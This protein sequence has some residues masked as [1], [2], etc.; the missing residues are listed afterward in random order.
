MIIRLKTCMMLAFSIGVSAAELP[1]RHPYLADSVNPLGHGDAAQQDSVSVSGPVNPGAMVARELIQY[2]PSGPAQFGA[3]TSGPYPN[4]SRVFWANGLDRIVKI[5][6]DTFEILSTYWFD[7][8]KRWTEDEADSAI[9]YFNK[10]KQGIGSVWRAFQEASKLKEL[11]GVYTV[12]D[13]DNTYFIADKYGTVTAYGD[14]NPMDPASSI[15]AKRSFSLPA[16]VT[17]YTVGMNM[18]YDGWLVV[19]TEHGY[20]VAISRD[21][22]SSYVVKLHNSDN[23]EIKATRPTGYGWVRNSIAIDAYGGIYVASQDHMHKIIWTGSGFSK[24]RDNGAWTVP[25][26]NSW[27]H[28]TGATPSLMGFGNEDQFVVITDGEHLMNVVLFWRNEI[29]EDWEGLSGFSRRIAGLQPANMGNPELTNI[30]SEQAV[31]IAGYG[32]LVVNNEP[33]NAPWWVPDQAKKLL[34]SYLGSSPT[35]QPYGVQKFTWNPKSRRFRQAWVNRTVSSP[36]CVPIVSRTSDLAFLIGARNSKWTLEAVEWQTG[37]SAYHSIIGDERYN[38]F[39][40]GTLIDEA[41]RIH[42]GSPWGRVRLNLP[43]ALSTG[44]MVD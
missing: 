38:P 20:L 8:V 18:T 32:A 35:Y 29:P 3:Y 21:F 33:R 14:K 4:G 24:D 2:A 27:G 15:V 13:V 9:Q 1:P 31:V 40:S 28:G 11:S 34:I 7:D 6:F 41:G 10:S 23:A 17:G 26:L 22:Q 44:N 16:G 25:Y 19:P 30:Q 42:Y 43:T 5:D 36:S 39:F 37:K 12:L